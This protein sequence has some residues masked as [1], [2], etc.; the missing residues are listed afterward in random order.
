MDTD[1]NIS[2]KQTNGTAAFSQRVRLF[3]FGAD[4][5]FKSIVGFACV[6]LLHRP[7]Q[8]IPVAAA[9]AL[10][11]HTQTLHGIVRLSSRSFRNSQ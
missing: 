2:Q 8:H 3:V 10:L 1:A 7:C 6:E 9:S 5:Y 11:H 4:T